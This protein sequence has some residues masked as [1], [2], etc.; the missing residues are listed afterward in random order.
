MVKPKLKTLDQLETEDRIVSSLPIVQFHCPFAYT[1]IL[2][3]IIPV[4]LIFSYSDNK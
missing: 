1:S 2:E 3:C 4:G